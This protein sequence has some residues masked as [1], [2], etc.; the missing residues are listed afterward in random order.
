MTQSIVSF[1]EARSNHLEYVLDG[2]Q[3]VTVEKLQ[4]LNNHLVEDSK[5]KSFIQRFFGKAY[6]PKG[7]YIWGGVGRGKTFLMDLFFESVEISKKRR[8]HF[9]RFMQEVHHRLKELQGTESPLRVIGREFA[10]DVRLLC[11][12]EFHISDIGDAMIMRNLLDALFEQNVTIVTTANWEPDRLYEHG[13]QRV[14]FLPT[15]ELI[16]NR[17]DVVNLDGGNDYR[18][19]SLE[20][21]G[22]FFLGDDERTDGEMRA[23]MKSL[24]QAIGEPGVISLNDR[25]IPYEAMS[26][27]LIWFTFRGICEGPRG[28]DDY[29]ELSKEFQTVLISKIPVFSNHNDNERRRF[30]WLVDEF[31]DRRVKLVL[32]SHDAIPAIFSDSLGGPEKERTE[33]RLIEMQSRRYLSEPHT[34]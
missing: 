3:R 29:I 32:S 23:L 33:S 2:A 4:D 20:K 19:A 1:V 30:T 22:V 18:L 14:Q 12:D 11:L 17:M 5:E 6:S 24:S 21:S 26:E 25:R 15:I 27:D 9:H 8:V 10:R 34:P 16:K 31:Y 13:L 28:K 7:M